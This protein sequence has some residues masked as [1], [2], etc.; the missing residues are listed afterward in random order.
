MPR[1]NGEHLEFVRWSP[2]QAVR[3]GSFGI[4]EPTDGEVV[5][6]ALHDVVLAP[7]VAFD[8]DRQS[9]RPGRR[10]LRSGACSLRRPPADRD[11]YRP[12]VPAGRAASRPKTWDVRIDA[13][14]TEDEVLE[15]RPGALD[16]S[17]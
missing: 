9:T 2:D 4:P 12:F 11:R 1:V 8:R 7:L 16:G 15:F 17:I 13:V 3:S 10:L 14:V 5:P 6:L